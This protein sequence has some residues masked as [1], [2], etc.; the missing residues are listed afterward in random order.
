MRL[1]MVQYAGD[2]REAVECF[3]QGGKETYYAQKY[4]VEAVAEIGKTIEKVAVLRCL[5]QEPYDLVLTRD[6][7]NTFF[8]SH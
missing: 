7:K 2:Y 3:A 8:Y 4:S 6:T 1:L 5:T